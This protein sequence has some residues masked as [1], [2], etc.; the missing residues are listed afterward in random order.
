[1]HLPDVCIRAALPVA[2][3][4]TLPYPIVVIIIYQN[5][6]HHADNRDNDGAPK[7]RPEAVDVKTYIKP[8]IGNP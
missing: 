7:G 4:A 3:A 6:E 1:M 5:V 8:V 2:T